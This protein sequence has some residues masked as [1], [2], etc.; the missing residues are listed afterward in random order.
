MERKE[1][2]DG[3]AVG[4][5]FGFKES[6]RYNIVEPGAFDGAVA[7]SG[8]ELDFV[9]PGFAVIAERKQCSEQRKDI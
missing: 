5:P 4:E 3:K 7:L 9:D 2:R 1:L 8:D 6:L